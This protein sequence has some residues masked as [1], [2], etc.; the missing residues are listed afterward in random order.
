MQDSFVKQN[1]SEYSWKWVEAP[2][3]YD[4]VMC[5]QEK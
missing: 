3:V 2:S 1:A 4:D 5:A